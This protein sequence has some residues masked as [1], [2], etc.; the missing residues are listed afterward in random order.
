MPV[1]LEARSLYRVTILT[2][3]R[4]SLREIDTVWV[5]DENQ[6]SQW[7]STVAKKWLCTFALLAVLKFASIRADSRLRGFDFVRG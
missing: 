5:L 1:L 7:G 6:Q 2:Q 3:V 4:D